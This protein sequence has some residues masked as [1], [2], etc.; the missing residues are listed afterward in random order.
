MVLETEI[1]VS[2]T[3]RCFFFWYQIFSTRTSRVRVSINEP[4]F[5]FYLMDYFPMNI[6]LRL[7]LTL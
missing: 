6:L 4:V 3:P 7:V 1:T 5:V 2:L